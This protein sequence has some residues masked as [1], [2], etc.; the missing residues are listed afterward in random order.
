MIAM[1]LDALPGRFWTYACIS[2]LG[3]AAINS[4]VESRFVNVYSWRFC[5]NAARKAYDEAISLYR[6]HALRSW[7]LFIPDDRQLG[8][9]SYTLT[10]DGTCPMIQTLLGL[11]NLRVILTKPRALTPQELRFDDSPVYLVSNGEL[12]RLSQLLIN[13]VIPVKSHSDGKFNLTPEGNAEIWINC[14]NAL[15]TTV[16]FWNGAALATEFGSSHGLTALVPPR[17]LSAPG[18]ANVS[19]RDPQSGSESAPYAF[20][21]TT[22]GEQ[23]PRPVLR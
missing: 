4:A 1:A 20:R 10:A 19:I 11:P 22:T 17:L 21:I 3:L 9:W 2:L 23:A 14:Q 6:G 5:E 15:P 13:S 7:T 16:V 12:V 18:I 8:F